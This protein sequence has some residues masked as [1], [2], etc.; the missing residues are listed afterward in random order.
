M[1]ASSAGG[2]RISRRV[3]VVGGGS[4]GVIAARFLKRAGHQPTVFEAGSSFGGVWADAPTND[5]VYK[6]LQTNLPTVVMQSPDLDFP[7]GLPSYITKPQLGRY[8]ESYADAFG[9]TPLARFGAQVSRVTPKVSG[10]EAWEVEWT[11]RDGVTQEDTFDAVVVANG[12]YEAPYVPK[13]PGQDEWLSGGDGRRSILHSR[14]YDEPS[15]FRGKSVLV[16]G[17]RS[18]GVDISRE[19]NGV[20]GWT[21][22]LEKGC[23]EP[24]THT[25]E[26]VTHIPLGARLCRDGKLRLGSDGTHDGVELPGPPVDTVILAT[27][28][29]YSFPFLDEE[30]TGMTFRGQRHVTPLYQ[31]LL[32]ASR[33]TLG[34]IGIQLA[35]PCPIPFFECQALYL[36]E[37]WARP[38]DAALTTQTEREAWVATRRAAVADRPQDMHVTGALGGSAWQYMRE[39]IDQVH[40]GR[41]P[42]P[43]GDSWLERPDWEARLL[44]VESVYRDRGG[45]YPTRPWDDDAY[46]RCEYTV[47]WT[48]GD[49]SVD[50]TRCGDRKQG[51]AAVSSIGA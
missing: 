23:A 4:A 40:E 19:L 12:H 36:A 31:H 37:A 42:T 20:A 48:T 34:F 3:A 39:L 50:D 10:G 1:P 45:R 41:P 38:P 28:Y 13:L 24:V 7:A 35:V 5:V 25:D 51:A 8:I 43:D 17:G 29:V 27:G 9:V 47:D 32:H 22:I 14:A 33:P 46:R 15:I 21:Y 6:N 44:T 30:S 11:E 2:S 16:V 26:A 18:S 49:W